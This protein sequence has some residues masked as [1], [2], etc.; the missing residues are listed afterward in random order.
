MAE[1]GDDI[2]Y[3]LVNELHPVNVTFNHAALRAYEEFGDF[4]GYMF[5]DSGINF[6]DNPNV[7]KDMWELYRS[8]PYG[9]VAARTDTDTGTF[10]WFNE[11]THHGDE[12]G[13]NKLFENGHL[14]FPI[15]KTTNLHCQIFSKDIFFGM[16]KRLMPDIFASHCTESTFTFITAAVGQQFVM[17]KDVV[18]SHIVGMDGPSAGFRP[19]K[20]GIVPWRHLYRSP[21]SIDEIISDPAAL[22]SGFGYE[23]CQGI[24]MHDESKYNERG[25]AL[26]P[27]KLNDF[28]KNNIYLPESALNYSEINHKFIK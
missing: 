16:G 25:Y 7:L 3:N 17:H 15:G 10:L 14:I 21:K 18:V 27:K 6:N 1:F 26:T 22:E 19:E 8:G 23:E 4:D 28:I 11:G 9:M 13:Q 2:S 24:L 12:S 5:M 20:Q